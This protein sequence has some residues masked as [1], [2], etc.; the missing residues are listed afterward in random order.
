VP[1]FD[2]RERRFLS[3]KSTNDLLVLFR[4]D[5]ARGID[6]PPARPEPTTGRLEQL[7]LPSG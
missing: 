1:L 2:E 5:A 6:E 4:L 7:R 3:Q